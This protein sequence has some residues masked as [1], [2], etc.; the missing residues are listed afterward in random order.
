MITCTRRIEFDAGH[1]VLGHK[2]KCRHPHGHRYIVEVTAI[3]P[4][5]NTLGMVTDFAL[6]KEQCGGWIDEHWDHGFLVN[7]EDNEMRNALS[8]V[9]D[10]KVYVLPFNPTAE[11]IAHYLANTFTYI[12]GRYGI[13]VRHTRVYETPNCWADFTNDDN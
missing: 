10:S 1:R 2:G 8:S 4:K 12:M 13:L 11:N 5:L 9:T 3:A 7:A 6:L